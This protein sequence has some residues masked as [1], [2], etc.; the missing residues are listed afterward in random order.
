MPD[1]LNPRDHVI[2]VTLIG[3][4]VRITCVNPGRRGS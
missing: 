4:G 3:T 1:F 2:V